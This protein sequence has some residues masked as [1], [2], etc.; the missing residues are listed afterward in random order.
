MN[1]ILHG[2]LVK[3]CPTASVTFAG[4]HH[5]PPHCAHI[6]CLI[7]RNT[8]QALVNVSGCNFF[9][10][11]EYNSTPLLHKHFHFRHYF[12]KLP[13][14]CYLLQ[15][16]YITEYWCEGSTSTV[17]PPISASDI[18]GQHN[19]NTGDVTFRA[20]LVLNFNYGQA[21]TK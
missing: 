18:M 4:T 7:S 2:E 16:I 6:H 10:I 3:I 21:Q 9:H 20:A 13:H 1:N 12:I 15:S 8:Q 14:Y 17:I 11:E 19:Y 5:P